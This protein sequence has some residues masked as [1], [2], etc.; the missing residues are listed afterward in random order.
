M[1]EGS[2]S[3]VFTYRAITFSE[4]DDVDDA[5]ESLAPVVPIIALGPRRRLPLQGI[6]DSG[7]DCS[8]FSH[9]VMAP[10]GISEKDCQL[11]VC[12]TAGGE[13]SHYVLADGIEIELPDLNRSLRVE[14][15]FSRGVERGIALL[16]R[17]DFF[18]AFRVS[19]DQKSL[20]FA[21]H[22]YDQ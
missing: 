3:H 22:P 18:A 1:Y 4:D 5:R 10:L 16:G 12:E 8:L 21:L 13:A 20:T 17:R 14:A 2:G 9:A 19:F 15:A 11:E 7:A 6:I